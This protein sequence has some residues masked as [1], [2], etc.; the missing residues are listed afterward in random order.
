MNSGAMTHPVAG[1]SIRASRCVA[2]RKLDGTIPDA[3][4]EWIAAC[5]T[6]TLSVP[7]TCPRSDE[8]VQNWS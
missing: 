8:V 6:R 7:A 5:S 4:P 3:S 1:S 2:M